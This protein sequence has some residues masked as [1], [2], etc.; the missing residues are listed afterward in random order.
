MT[1]EPTTLSIED[2]KAWLELLPK[3]TPGPWGWDVEDAS[4][5]SLGVLPNP[6]LGDPHVLSVSPCKSCRGDEWEWGKC[7]TPSEADA[8]HIA[9]CDPA[10]IAALIEGYIAMAEALKPFAEAAD[11]YDPSED[12]E[13][14]SAWAHEFTIGSL[15]RA[16][17]ALNIGGTND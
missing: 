11:V 4:M 6:G 8:A 17:T 15:R 1:S 14:A 10:T 3:V 9:K 12:E 13:W 5:A 7:L 2:L 16:R